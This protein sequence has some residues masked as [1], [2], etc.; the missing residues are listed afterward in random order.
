MYAY[1]GGTNRDSGAW[2]CRVINASF[3]TA[4]Q[5]DVQYCLDGEQPHRHGT[6]DAITVIET[7]A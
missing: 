6:G 1:T 3:T 5:Y 7:A 4:R 2:T